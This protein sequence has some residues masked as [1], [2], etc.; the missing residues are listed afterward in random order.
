MTTATAE[1]KTRTD[2]SAWMT[3]YREQGLFRGQAVEGALVL[4]ARHHARRT[5]RARADPTQQPPVLRERD[6]RVDVRVVL[7]GRPVDPREQPVAVELLDAG[8]NQ[9]NKCCTFHLDSP[10]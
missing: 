8:V 10:V 1:M 7:V 3:S 2:I 5:G 9:A 4:P 6:R